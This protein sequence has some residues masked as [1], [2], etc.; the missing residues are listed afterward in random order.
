M[1]EAL[2]AREVAQRR[3]TKNWL[4]E[5]ETKSDDRHGDN[6]LWEVGITDMTAK[7][8]AKQRA[9]EATPT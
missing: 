4:E 7:V 5:R 1:L 8:L 2:A 9:G 3:G 6:I